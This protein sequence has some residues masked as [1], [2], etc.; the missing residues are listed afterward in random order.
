MK[1]YSYLNIKF[2]GKKNAFTKRFYSR[3]DSMGENYGSSGSFRGYYGF[4]DYANRA[5]FFKDI[6]D[7]LVKGNI[8]S[9][10]IDNDEIFDLYQAYRN[11]TYD[12]QINKVVEIVKNIVK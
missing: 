10:T 2:S 6:K 4:K 8:V 5:E 7:A 9:L 11:N 1:P 3:I 12:E